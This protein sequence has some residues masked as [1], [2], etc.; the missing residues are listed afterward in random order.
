MS[1]L[2]SYYSDYS[3]ENINKELQEGKTR[4]ELAGEYGHKDFK[5]IDMLMRRNGYKWDRDR[6]YYI[7]REA[8][9]YTSE[10]HTPNKKT[11]RRAL[12]LFDRGK[13][14]KEVAEELGFSSHMDLAGYM[15][16]HNYFWN[17]KTQKYEYKSDANGGAAKESKTEPKVNVS[18]FCEDETIKLLLDNR[19]KLMEM[20]DSME[21]RALPRYALSGVRVPKTVLMA[22]KLHELV[23]SFV[24]DKGINQRE[25][26]EVAVIETMRRYGYDAEIRGLLG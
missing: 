2:A 6:G 13:E 19:E 14:P 17:S 9:N 24:E 26:Y 7:S 16:K 4:D 23:K 12:E 25:F 20:F 18:S 15:R 11:L 21:G 3:P 8:P 1:I 10:E 5:A 22:N